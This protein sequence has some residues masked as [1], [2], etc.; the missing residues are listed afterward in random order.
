M[1][2]AVD[3]VR[4]LTTNPCVHEGIK[5]VNALNS[6]IVGLQN[7]AL[8]KDGAKVEKKEAAQQLS[9]ESK[10]EKLKKSIEGGA[11]QLDMDKTAKAL[12]GF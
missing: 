8:Q 9:E 1:S 12:V 3:I 4:E 11:Y 10:V 2:L 7:Q 5:M 6:G